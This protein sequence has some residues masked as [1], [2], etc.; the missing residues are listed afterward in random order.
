LHPV[1]RASVD[2]RLA[3]ATA[4]ERGIFSVPGRSVVVWVIQ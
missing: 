1:Q 4:S 3:Q 2:P